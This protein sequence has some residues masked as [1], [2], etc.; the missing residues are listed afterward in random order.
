ML[1]QQGD[2]YAD[3]GEVL[4][5]GGKTDEAI[6]AIEQAVERYERKGNVVSTERAQ[7]RLAEIR[8]GAQTSPT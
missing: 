8:S 6:A 3:L 2:T 5:L 1:V 7:A 4:L